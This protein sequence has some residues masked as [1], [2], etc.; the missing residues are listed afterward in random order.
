MKRTTEEIK[1]EL[2]R[3]RDVYYE[4]K[5]RQQQKCM[6]VCASVFIGT[7]LLLFCASL[8]GT[9]PQLIQRNPSQESAVSDG[10]VQTPSTTSFVQ[11]GENRGGGTIK[12]KLFKDIVRVDITLLCSQEKPLRR[13]TAPDKVR[14][15]LS[16]V[17]VIAEGNIYEAA[18][19]SI[20][21]DGYMITV[22][23]KKGNLSEYRLLNDRLV[24][25]STDQ[26]Y[27]VT[28]EQKAALEDLID[29]L[30]SDE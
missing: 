1:A 13:Y 21:E 7:V 17:E 9:I 27:G 28:N 12:E 22:A 26:W 2:F 23:D 25:V 29:A 19:E 15:V 20:S 11:D 8:E 3:R 5:H 4:K 6:A 18:P 16:C 30:P 14:S 24:C 10:M